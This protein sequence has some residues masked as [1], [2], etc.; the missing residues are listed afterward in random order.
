METFTGQYGFVLELDSETKNI[1]TNLSEQYSNNLV[2]I[3]QRIPHLTLFHTSIKNAPITEVRNMLSNIVA[4]LPVS[5]NFY[6][7][8]S[9]G[10]HFVFWQC[11]KTKELVAVHKRSLSLAKYFSPDSDVKKENLILP[12]D[13][14]E[15]IKRYGHPLVLAQWS[16]HVTLA[17]TDANPKI[18]SHAYKHATSSVA[19]NFVKIGLYGSIQ[20]VVL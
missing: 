7:I 8:V 10:E 16:P 6:N 17:Y 12:E 2:P 15:N 13:Q 20:E 11:V 9:F 19:V 18:V 4:D 14:E 3:N 5:L 1:A